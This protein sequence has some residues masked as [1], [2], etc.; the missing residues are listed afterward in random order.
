MKKLSILLLSFVLVAGFTQA[1]SKQK[2]GH[3]NTGELLQTMPER[4]EA[5]KAIQE[6]AKQLEKQLSTMS[7]EYQAKVQDYQTNEATWS[8]LIKD[9]KV[10]EIGD[11]ETRIQEFQGTAQENLQKPP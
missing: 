10:K 4:T 9:T 11:L 2:F 6:E 5:E 7:A 1:Q 3:I 8:Q